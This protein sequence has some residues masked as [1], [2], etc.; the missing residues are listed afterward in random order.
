MSILDNYNVDY[1]ILLRDYIKNPL[2]LGCNQYTNP[3]EMPFKE[4]LEYLYIKLN[5]PRNVLCDYFNCGVTK[6]KKWIKHY[7][8]KK[9]QIHIRFNKFKTSNKTL[10]ILLNKDRLNTYIIDNNITTYQEVAIKLGISCAL[11]SKY[12]KLY[13]LD[14]HFKKRGTSYEEKELQI[15]LNSYIKIICN[16]RTIIK[17]LELDIYIPSKN[18]EI[19]FNGSYWH[20]YNLFPNVYKRDM[21][22]REMCKQ[23]GIKL[24]TVLEND[25]L[26]NKENVKRELLEIIFNK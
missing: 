24:I 26:N 3:A 15:F 13:K 14:T 19:E 23:K 5:I 22:K 1:S 8:I 2:K 9:S 25:W 12:I 16:D 11:A 4:D 7:N 21:K 18:I 6:W 17:P 10:N 20:N